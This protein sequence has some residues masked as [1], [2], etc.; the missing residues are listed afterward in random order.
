MN[1]SFKKK[2]EVNVICRYWK[3]ISGLDFS[4]RIYVPVVI[5]FLTFFY[6]NIIVLQCVFLL[7][8]EVKQ[9]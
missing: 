5:F 1:N 4:F 7:Y 3:L 2:S 6:W 8:T 9:L